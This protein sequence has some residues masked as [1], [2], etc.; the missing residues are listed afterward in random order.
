MIFMKVR[1]TGILLQNDSILLL[2]QN[3]NEGSRTWSLPGGTLEEGE[4]L[5]G[6]LIREMREETG[7]N[8]TVKELLY[9]ADNITENGHVVHITFLVDSTG[10]KLGDIAEGVDSNKIRDVVFVPVKNLEDY[11]FTSLFRDLVSKNFP[12]KGSYV[13]AKKNIGL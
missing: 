8:T 12:N 6:A 3:V 4:T 11:G 2:D 5:K 1:V 7:L 9:V 13:D 10:G